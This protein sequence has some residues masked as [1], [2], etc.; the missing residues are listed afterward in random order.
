MTTLG[1]GQRKIPP[2]PPGSLHLALQREF[3]TLLDELT[4]RTPADFG[5]EITRPQ[6]GLPN[7][8]GEVGMRGFGERDRRGLHAARGV[9]DES[10][11]DAALEQCSAQRG[12]I[13]GS[14]IATAR[15]DCFVHHRRRE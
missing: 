5:R 3:K 1:G 6:K 10:R 12:W 14:G 8:C 9:D 4:D 13:D 7:R 11:N 2:T 15:L